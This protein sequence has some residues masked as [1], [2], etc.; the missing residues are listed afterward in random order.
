[1]VHG[2]LIWSSYKT[3]KYNFLKET[4]QTGPSEKT[5]RTE[6][7]CQMNPCKSST[8]LQLQA[9]LPQTRKINILLKCK[10]FSSQNLQGY[11][12]LLSA[13]QKFMVQHSVLM[14]F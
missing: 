14:V 12:C 4:V 13:S 6:I 2:P 3:D 11:Q 5:F 1:M 9:R 10:L 7:V 8:Q